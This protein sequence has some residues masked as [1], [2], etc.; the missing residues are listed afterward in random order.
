MTKPPTWPDRRA[1][2]LHNSFPICAAMS[3]TSDV[4]VAGLPHRCTLHSQ[5]HARKLAHYNSIRW[6]W[7]CESATSCNVAPGLT[8]TLHSTNNDVTISGCKGMHLQ[9]PLQCRVMLPW[10]LLV[11]ADATAAVMPTTTDM[12]C[13]QHC[14][15]PN[16]QGTTFCA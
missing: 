7:W 8:S 1:P 12:Y 10:M 13:T 14:V 6:T 15:L 5:K 4:P 16:K 3:A 9:Q 2:V 11:S